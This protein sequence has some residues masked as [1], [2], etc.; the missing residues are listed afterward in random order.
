MENP[1]ISKKAISPG[2]ELA[3]KPRGRPPLPRAKT[4]AERARDYRA[5]KIARR[6][7]LRDTAIPPTSKILDLSGDIAR[8]LEERDKR[9]VGQVRQAKF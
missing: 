1:S 3:K 6:L 7:A 4:D 9:Q 8:A 2:V 5:R